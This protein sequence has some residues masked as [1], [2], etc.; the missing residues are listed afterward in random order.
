[1]KKLPLY[2]LTFFL[3]S[4]V[5]IVFYFAVPYLLNGSMTIVLRGYEVTGNAE[6]VRNHLLEYRGEAEGHEMAIAF[7]TWGIHRPDEFVKIVEGTESSKK[8]ELCSRL[9]FAATDTGLDEKFDAA[10]ED[11]DSEC[12]R[13]IRTEILKSRNY[14]NR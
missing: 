3:L 5:V 7:L 1:M 9:A 14:Q 8:A 4:A 10:F 2:L 6:S 11:L 12:L 13:T